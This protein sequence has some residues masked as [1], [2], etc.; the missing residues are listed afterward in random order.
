MV[1]T[2]IVLHPRITNHG[3]SETPDGFSINNNVF[4]E[5]QELFNKNPTIQGTSWRTGNHQD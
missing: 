5:N 1:L 3:E 4:V 2:E